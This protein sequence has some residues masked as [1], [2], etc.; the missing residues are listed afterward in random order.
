MKTPTIP[1]SRV[2]ARHPSARSSDLGDIYRG[3]R[4][5]K[6]LR[7]GSPNATPEPERVP[8][9]EMQPLGKMAAK[10]A[11]NPQKTLNKFDPV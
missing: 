6:P 2:T 10:F 3:P 4:R 1:K 8:V 5:A 7:I 9:P 11:P